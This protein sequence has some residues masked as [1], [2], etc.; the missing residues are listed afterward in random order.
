MAR[1]RGH[2]TARLRQT[3]DVIGIKSLFASVLE[4]AQDLQVVLAELAERARRRGAKINAVVKDAMQRSQTRSI[5]CQ[6]TDVDERERTSEPADC[7]QQYRRVVG[8][9]PYGSRRDRIDT[10]SEDGRSSAVSV[11]SNEDR[12]RGQLRRCDAGLAALREYDARFRQVLNS[13]GRYDNDRQP[14]VSDERT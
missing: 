3:T 1:W 6:L 12:V 4:N 9:S 14:A 7:D 13:S 2:H 10:E 5:R 8:V 11:E